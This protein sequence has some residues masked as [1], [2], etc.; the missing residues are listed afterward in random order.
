MSQPDNLDTPTVVVP[1]EPD[2]RMVLAGSQA[3]DAWSDGALAETVDGSEMARRVW[4][5]MASAAKTGK[6]QPT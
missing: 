3:L 5:A 6:E 2:W 4:K 1:C